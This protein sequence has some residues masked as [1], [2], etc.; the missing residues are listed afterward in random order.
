MSLL[1]QLYVVSLCC[2]MGSHGLSGLQSAHTVI[3][4]I[5]PGNPVGLAV[6]AGCSGQ[7]GLWIP[8]VRHPSP[9]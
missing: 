5:S 4:F 9:L 8:L 3:S 1:T 6:V 2:P 7:Q